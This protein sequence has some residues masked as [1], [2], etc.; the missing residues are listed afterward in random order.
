[1]ISRFPDHS[2]LP[3]QSDAET[4]LQHEAHV[5]QLISAFQSLEETLLALVGPVEPQ[6]SETPCSVRAFDRRAGIFPQ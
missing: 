1:M 4:C 5:R 6:S 3:S 2:Q